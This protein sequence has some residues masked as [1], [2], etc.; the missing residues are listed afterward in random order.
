[1]QVNSATEFSFADLM[2]IPVSTVLTKYSKKDLNIPALDYIF[3]KCVST[4][5]VHQQPCNPVYPEHEEAQT[6]STVPFCLGS[7]SCIPKFHV[8]LPLTTC[9]LTE[10]KIQTFIKHWGL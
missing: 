1:M 2:A 9:H 7:F 8:K 3:S 4:P 10:H 6:T 5:N